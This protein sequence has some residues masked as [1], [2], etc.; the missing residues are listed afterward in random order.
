M[1][2]ADSKNIRSEATFPHF[3]Q[4]FRNEFN[5]A[6][7]CAIDQTTTFVVFLI[8]GLYHQGCG[9]ST[10]LWSHHNVRFINLCTK[11]DHTFI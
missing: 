6:Q 7:T 5:I 11:A 3:R 2:S 9:G 8:T 10:D 4:E 1:N